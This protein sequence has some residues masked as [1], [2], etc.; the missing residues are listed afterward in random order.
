[1]R[2]AEEHIHFY[3]L[4]DN[5]NL[6]RNPAERLPF[7]FSTGDVLAGLWN[8]GTGCTASHS[9]TAFQRDDT[10]K[11]INILVAFSTEGDCPYELVRG[12][13]LGI[14]NAQDYQITIAYGE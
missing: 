5:S 6:C 3:N 10:T 13:W 1:L 4:V 12:F 11:V 14:H 8:R 7:D 2:S 9:I